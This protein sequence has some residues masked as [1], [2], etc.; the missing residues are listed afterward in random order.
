MDLQLQGRVAAVAAASSGLGKATALELAKEGARVAICSRGQDRI[1]QAAQ[2][3]SA[4]SGGE[5]FPIAADVSTKAGCNHFIAEA[6]SHYGGL[7]IL[8]TNAGGPAAGPAEQITDE[9]WLSAI[10]LN[11]LSAIRM[12][13]A[14]LPHLRQSN[15]G[16]VIAITSISAKQPLENLILSNATR[17]GVLGFMK[18]MANELGHTGIT[19][20][21]VLPGWTRTARVVELLDNLSQTRQASVG[22]VESG[23]T[24]AIPAGHMGTV[25]DF[26]AAVVFLASGRSEYI[27]GL[28]I[29]IDGGQV[30]A[31]F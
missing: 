19:F 7:D 26:A 10:D 5:I 25:E 11:L 23:I 13:Y 27:N 9:Q 28:S 6:T 24:A 1:R 14:A 22:E 18:S 31:L 30:K 20:N 3:L 29:Q 4:V 15:Q 12:V 16:R 2:E 17:A 8:I 21:A